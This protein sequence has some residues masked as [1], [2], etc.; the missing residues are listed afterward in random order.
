MISEGIKRG[1]RLYHILQTKNLG[2]SKSTVY[3]HLQKGYLTVSPI[4]FPRVVKFRARKQKPSEYVPRA[5]KVGRTYDDFLAYIA[6]NDISSWVEMDTV[7]GRIGGKVIVTFDFTFGNFMFGCLLENKTSL[8]VTQKIR[9]IKAALVMKERRFGGLFPVIL[10]DNGGEFANVSAVENDMDGN[11]ETRL[12]FCDPNR[13]YQKPYVE[14]NHTIF[15][16]IVPKGVS[17]DDFTQDTVNLIFSHV[18]SI[19]RKSLSGKSPFEMFVFLY[20]EM[21][22]KTLGIECIPS[23]DVIQS[24][25]LLILFRYKIYS[26]IRQDMI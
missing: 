11:R 2:V 18:N 6:A 21:T 1:Q 14:K 22:A 15:R 25:L 19:K 24:P 5:A 20:G 16:D 12:F 9:G 23:E 8:E 10:T 7:L 17:F 3:R 26:K 4:D 13:A